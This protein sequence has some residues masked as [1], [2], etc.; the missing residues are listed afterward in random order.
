MKFENKVKEIVSSEIFL[1]Y[2]IVV[3]SRYRVKF[4]FT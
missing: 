4:D 2:N 3:N 1:T